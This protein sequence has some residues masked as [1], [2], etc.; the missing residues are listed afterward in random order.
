[1]ENTKTREPQQK[2]SIE[3]K[4]RIIEIGFRLMC[5]KGYQNTTT[6]DI[7]KA[8]GV[9]TG[10]IYSY[11]KDKHDIFIC[12]LEVYGNKLL[13]PIYSEITPDIDIYKSLEKIIDSL[14]EGHRIFENFHKE[15]GALTMTD[16]A[17]AQIM[18]DTEIKTTKQLEV[19]LSQVG[20][21]ITNLSEKTHVIYN[22]VEALCHEITFHN[23]KELNYDKMRQIVIDAVIHILG[24]PRK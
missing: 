1:M 15:I 8:A 6:A 11:F 22:L 10:I 17:V 4:N 14:V 7:A 18:L 24:E 12:G 3:K 13:A 16:E 5:E 23:H 9:S 19:M 2:R 21:D 20:F